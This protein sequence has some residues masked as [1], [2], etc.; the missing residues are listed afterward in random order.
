[1]SSPGLCT[2]GG[3]I[4]GRG[5]L[6]TLGAVVAAAVGGGVAGGGA[7]IGGRVWGAESVVGVTATRTGVPSVGRAGTAP[8]VVASTTRPTDNTPVSPAAIFTAA[9]VGLRLRWRRSD[10]VR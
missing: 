4:V 8:P 9:G 1:M 7:G 3:G 2:I 10:V 6:T 5:V